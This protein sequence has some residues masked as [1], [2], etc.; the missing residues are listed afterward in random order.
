[1]RKQKGGHWAAICL[2]FYAVIFLVASVNAFKPC[3]ESIH[4]NPLEEPGLTCRDTTI[5]FFGT[6]ETETS[7]SRQR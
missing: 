1:M 4:W 2:G 3:G 6:P 7:A 5:L